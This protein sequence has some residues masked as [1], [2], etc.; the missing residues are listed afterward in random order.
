M[1]WNEKGQLAEMLE[2]FKGRQKCT[3]CG[4]TGYTLCSS[5]R[6]GKK[7]PKTFHNTNLRCAFCDENGI[8]P[9]KMC[10]C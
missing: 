4:D 10:L 5:C 1:E 3:T 6:G 8:V 7:S 9:C 2:E